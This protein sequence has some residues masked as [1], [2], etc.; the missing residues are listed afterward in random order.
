MGKTFSLLVMLMMPLLLFACGSVEVA[1]LAAVKDSHL[2]VYIKISAKTAKQY[3][4]LAVAQSLTNESFF[5]VDVRTNEEFREKHIKWAINIPNEEIIAAPP[6]LPTK[7]AIILVYCRS[8]NRSAQAAKKLIA[9]GY[10]Y[11]FDFGGI[12]AWTYEF[13]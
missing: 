12:N 6:L 2:G 13:A 5:I 1:S 3:L 9:L 10:L 11:V 8:G 4:D 7:E